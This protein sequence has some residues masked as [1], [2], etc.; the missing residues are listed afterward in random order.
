MEPV[1]QKKRRNAA[2]RQWSSPDGAEFLCSSELQ[3]QEKLQLWEKRVGL[4]PLSVHIG[5]AHTLDPSTVWDL[6]RPPQLAGPNELSRPEKVEPALPAPGPS[7]AGRR[8]D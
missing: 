8:G 1:T 7:G 3:E 6:R 2:D 5:P 4:A